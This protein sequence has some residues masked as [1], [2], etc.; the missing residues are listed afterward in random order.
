MTFGSTASTPGDADDD[1][2]ECYS[3]QL[4]SASVPNINNLHD[5]LDRVAVDGDTCYMCA[6]TKAFEFFENTPPIKDGEKRSV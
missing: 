2:P 6:L 5:F 4:V 3:T 1:L